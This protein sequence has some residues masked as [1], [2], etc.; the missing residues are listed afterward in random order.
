MNKKAK[1]AIIALL[2]FSTACSTLK[3]TS[4]SNDKERENKQTEGPIIT[5]PSQSSQDTMPLT[6][7]GAPQPSIEMVELQDVDS[8][9]T[10]NNS[11]TS[12]IK[13]V[14]KN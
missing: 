13:E 6:M 5:P 11:V 14:N 3:N 2:G 8:L 9:H 1:L 12:V 4:K 7:Y 10:T